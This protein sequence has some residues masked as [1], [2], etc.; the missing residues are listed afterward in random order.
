MEGKEKGIKTRESVHYWSC[1]LQGMFLSQWGDTL[2]LHRD[3]QADCT[4]GWRRHMEQNGKR[5]QGK[6]KGRHSLD[7]KDQMW[8]TEDMRE[9]MKQSN[10]RNLKTLEDKEWKQTESMCSHLYSFKSPE[11]LSP[12][13]TFT[14]S[15]LLNPSVL[16]CALYHIPRC[17]LWSC[18]A[19]RF[20]LKN[21]CQGSQSGTQNV[22]NG[23]E[24]WSLGGGGPNLNLRSH[25]LWTWSNA[26]IEE[27]FLPKSD[28][29]SWQ[30]RISC[31]SQHGTRSTCADWCQQKHKH[32]ACGLWVGGRWQCGGTEDG[33]DPLQAQVMLWLN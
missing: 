32:T 27:I 15:T 2:G 23:T 16:V 33:S 5:K 26:R 24:M 28:R 8:L 29:G 11:S 30:G 3:Y 19:Y 6:I 18:L 25:R 13:P 20:F 7:W 1:T 10:Q 4:S 14:F 9:M 12:T 31:F 21:H 22:A 17:H